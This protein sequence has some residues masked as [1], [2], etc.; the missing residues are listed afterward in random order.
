LY[1]IYHNSFS[2][3]GDDQAELESLMEAAHLLQM[4]TKLLRRALYVFPPTFPKVLAPF[5]SYIAFYL[6]CSYVA[7]GASLT[8]ASVF[9]FLAHAEESN[10][11]LLQSAAQYYIAV[12]LSRVLELNKLQSADT[13]TLLAIARVYCEISD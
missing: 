1:F 12:N 9:N 5:V 8:P 13:K 7:A 4:N 10:S 2:Q 11:A 3:L 6:S